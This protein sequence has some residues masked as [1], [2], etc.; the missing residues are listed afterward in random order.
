M[1]SSGSAKKHIDMT[2]YDKSQTARKIIRVWNVAWALIGGFK[3]IWKKKY[4][5]NS[6]MDKKLTVVATI[7]E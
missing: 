2:K 3:K 1:L 4:I 5:I 6:N 7:F